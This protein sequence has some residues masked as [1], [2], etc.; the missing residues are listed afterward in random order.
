MDLFINCIASHAVVYSSNFCKSCILLA[1][2]SIGKTFCWGN[3]IENHC[4]CCVLAVW[5]RFKNVSFLGF[6]IIYYFVFK[7]L[8]N[9][10][11]CE[12]DSFKLPNY[13]FLYTKY[14][15]SCRRMSLYTLENVLHCLSCLFATVYGYK[16]IFEV[17]AR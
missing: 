8:W 2:T 5:Q 15:S 4:C 9:S 16:P 10:A 11:M 17:Q 14:I 12:T 7:S 6:P 1:S 13:L 3:C